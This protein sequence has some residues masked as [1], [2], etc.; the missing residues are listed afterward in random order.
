MSEGRYV[1]A[2]YE[3]P[4]PRCGCVSQWARRP[5]DLH[6]SGCRLALAIAQAT[7]SLAD[8]IADRDAW[9]QRALAAEGRQAE[10]EDEVHA[11]RRSA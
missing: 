2:W 4:C 3:A 1:G 5:D 7:L 11:A 6:C 9:R 10:L 8:L